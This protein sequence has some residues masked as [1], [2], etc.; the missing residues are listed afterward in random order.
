[1]ILVPHVVMAN[2]CR[3]GSP[4]HHGLGDAPRPGLRT[5]HQVPHVG[6]ERLLSRAMTFWDSAPST[7]VGNSQKWTVHPD[8]DLGARWP[9]VL[10]LAHRVDLVHADSEDDRS[11]EP[12]SELQSL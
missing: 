11:E 10:H 5:V 7:A 3:H 6:A 1:M 8:S 2:Y 9:E 4:L 12:T